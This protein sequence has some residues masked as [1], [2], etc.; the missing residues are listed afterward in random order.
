MNEDRRD[1]WA[2]APY[3]TSIMPFAFAPV[4]FD[5]TFH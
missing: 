4:N 2:V 3:I 1:D 5:S